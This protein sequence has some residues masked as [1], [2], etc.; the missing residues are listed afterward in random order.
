MADLREAVQ[1]LEEDRQTAEARVRAQARK[2]EEQVILGADAL[3]LE[4]GDLVRIMR[5]THVLSSMNAKR[6]N[7]LKF[8]AVGIGNALSGPPV[9]TIPRF[10][11]LQ[12]ATA[13][14]CIYSVHCHRVNSTGRLSLKQRLN[15][16]P[17]SHHSVEYIPCSSPC[18]DRSSREQQATIRCLKEACARGEERAS[19]AEARAEQKVL[20]P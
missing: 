1:T 4:G 7:S 15:F 13:R 6:T 14:S 20:L 3:T 16:L 5:K 12:D 18:Q 9:M 10:P 2:L 17:K 19:S 11:P 8:T